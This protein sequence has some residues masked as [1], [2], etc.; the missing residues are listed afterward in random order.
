VP[1]TPRYPS[2]DIGGTAGHN[3]GSARR[4][5]RL[6]YLWWAVGIALMLAFMVLHLTGVLGP[7]AH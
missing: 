6:T 4:K 2:D 3:E 5:P 1:E 7:G